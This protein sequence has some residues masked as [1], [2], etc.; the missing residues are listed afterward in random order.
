MNQPENLHII[1]ACPVPEL[2]RAFDR[3][4]TA[5]AAYVIERSEKTECEY[6]TTY[7]ELG[8]AFNVRERET[9]PVTSALRGDISTAHFSAGRP[10]LD[11]QGG[12]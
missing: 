1:N 3:W 5:L 9:G 8:E 4:L 2:A 10:P 6:N 12:R 11:S 7:F